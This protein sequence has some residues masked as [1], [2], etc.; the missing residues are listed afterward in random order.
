MSSCVSYLHLDWGWLFIT[1]FLEYLQS[2]LAYSTLGPGL[3]GFGAALTL[4]FYPL[5]LSSVV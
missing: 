5:Q 3:D 1:I 2:P 4:H